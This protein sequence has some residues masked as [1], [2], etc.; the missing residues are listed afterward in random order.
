MVGLLKSISFKKGAKNQGCTKFAE[1]CP[2]IKCKQ[3]EQNI[4]ISSA[5]LF[6]TVWMYSFFGVNWVT[7]KYLTW[8]L[9]KDSRKDASG[10]YTFEFFRFDLLKIG[11][12]TSFVLFCLRFDWGSFLQISCNLDFSAPFLKE[13]DFIY[14]L[15]VSLK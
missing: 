11:I 12:G 3:N 6:K 2:M 13:M 4:L 7:F 8:I 5:F 9:C 1:N 10:F 14:K 15:N